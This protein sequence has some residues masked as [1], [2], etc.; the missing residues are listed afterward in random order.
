MKKKE[1]KLAIIDL[2]NNEIN[3]GIRC[4][5]D[6]ITESNKNINSTQIRFDIFD[7][8]YKNEV[9]DM[10]Y[11]IFIS[12]GGP[13]SPFAG[14][15]Q[16]WEHD[17]FSIVDKIWNNNQREKEKKKYIFFI[18]HS[19]QMMA[20]YFKFAEVKER[21]E[22]SFGV[23]PFRRTEDGKRDPILSNLPDPFYAAD[24]RQF[25]VIE[26]NQR[27]L[28]ELGG[29]ILALE[30]EDKEMKHES[31]IMAVR[32][33]EEIA[34]TQFHPEADPTSMV[35]HLDQEERKKYVAETYGVDKYAEMLSYLEDP[36]KLK[37]TRR[38]VL[39]T[40]LELAIKALN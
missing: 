24:F 34:G 32:I 30:L 38:T 15:D 14:V 1:I 8:R 22:K 31:A 27:V 18:C 13:G 37:L 40:F 39:P 20:R 3:E 36:D 26:K 2:Y 33:S 19:F 4:I 12:S 21:Y 5:K 10:S 11:D 17:Y 16:K 25:E 9:P 29:K 7:I 28:N 35:Y 6:I 23:H